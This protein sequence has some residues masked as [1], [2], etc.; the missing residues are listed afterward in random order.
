MRRFTLIV[1]FIT[2]LQL[3]LPAARADTINVFAAASLKTALDEV[4][5]AWQAQSGNEARMVYAASS[6][7]ARQITEG[8]PADIYISAD[9]A[10]MD[11]LAAKSL[12]VGESR[13][14][15]LGN[16][17]VLI[18]PADSDARVTLAKPLDLLPLLKGG[19]L[20]VADVTA[21]PAGKYAR[22][23]LTALGAW[24]A[25]AD[26]LA[27]AE[28]VR[29]ALALVARGEVQLGIV[30]GSDAKA[31]P[32]VKVVATFAQDSYPEIVYPA[33]V[34]ITSANAAAQSFM[35]FLRAPEA[36]AIFEKSGFAVLK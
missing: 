18:A 17:L 25:V 21:V 12:I 32:Q 10:W 35:A 1:A 5:P 15:L 30:Y 3:I 19:R 24:D 26:H 11:E 2:S 22:A 8:A 7:L 34:V 13:I 9:T 23:A 36:A 4:G 29:A 14:D 6:A 33:A 27:Q 31:E 20:A 28:N 16:T